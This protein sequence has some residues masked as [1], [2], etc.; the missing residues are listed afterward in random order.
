[1]SMQYSYRRQR[2]CCLTCDEQLRYFV[3]CSVAKLHTG[4]YIADAGPTVRCA[5]AYADSS[6]RLS[7]GLRPHPL[8]PAASLPLRHRRYSP[9]PSPPT[10]QYSTT[11]KFQLQCCLSD[12]DQRA[13]AFIC[14][15]VQVDCLWPLS[16]GYLC[17]SGQVCRSAAAQVS[18]ALRMV[19]VLVVPVRRQPPLPHTRR[20]AA[21][22]RA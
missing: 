4:C 6:G 14:A 13:C 12:V 22:V 9:A 2:A 15:G 17:L 1:M 20:K 11:N 18:H 5:P 3:G 16:A 10:V 7:L 8:T 21:G 19:A